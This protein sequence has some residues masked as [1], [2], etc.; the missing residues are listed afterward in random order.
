MKR[1]IIHYI[2]P[3]LLAV[4]LTV[5][6]G[7]QGRQ[8]RANECNA[9]SLMNDAYEEHN[10]ERLVTLA[11]SLQ[12][13]KQLSE[14]KAYYWRGYSYSRQRKMRLAESQWKKA[15]G[16]HVITD[17]DLEYYAKSVN[18]LTAL[19]LLKGD[20]EAVMREAV[21]AIQ[22]LIDAG[23][24]NTSDYAFIQ[25]TVG[26]CQLRLGSQK[27]A[28]ASFERAY[29]IF[30]YVIDNNP[31]IS[32]Y[33]SAIAG[34]ITITDNHLSMKLFAEALAWSNRFAELID[35]YQQ[36]AKPDMDY[37][38]KQLARINLYRA[39]ALEGLGNHADAAKA[40]KEAMAT[41]Y[42]KTIDGRFETCNYLMSASRW[43]EAAHNFEVLD[44]LSSR[45]GRMFNLDYI[46]HFLLPK[47]KANIGAHNLDTA[48]AVGTLICNNLD[49]AI[50][51]VQLDEAS[52]LA[53]IYNTQQKETE[54]A[55]QKANLAR[56]QFVIVVIILVLV[57]IFFSLIMFFRHQSAKRLAAAYCKLEEANERIKE[58]SRMKT[59]F[60]QQISH[61]IRTPLNILSGFTQVITT[62]GMTLDEETKQD[63]NTKIMEN[64]NRI[65]GLVNKMLELSDVNS[66][67]VIERND[68]V[69]AIQVAAEAMNA[70]TDDTKYTIPIDLQLAEGVDSIMLQTNEQAATRSL[71]LVLGNA[72]R[73]TKEGV[74]RLK[75]EHDATMVRFVVEDTGIG[76]PV[77]EAEHIFEEFV[78]L[79]EYEEGTGIGLTVSRSICRRLGGDVVLDT[80]YT[81]GAR[82]VL[83]L[84]LT[85]EAK[86]E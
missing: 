36:Q 86:A 77:S 73:F 61:E 53:A 23:K 56:Q 15:I 9:D 32:N 8:E 16:L 25:A 67:A 13:L 60:I 69:L 18:R 26:C 52:E 12:E 22:L 7:E 68:Q 74:V 29:Q 85:I 48:I 54:L 46:Q 78:Q 57:I 31:S 27:E 81:G 50:L 49:S 5:S 70:F 64:T 51:R 62:P 38:D 47:Y 59:S 72:E 40:Y 55:E 75:V 76:V 19:Q 71:V 21:P 79:N 3:V 41:H 20:Y 30:L 66:K 44:Q 33:T 1:S 39:C 65:T 84:P 80:S 6:C 14:M 28:A 2:L 34:I 83:T 58:S 11:D 63:I 45:Y 24:N 37:L 82:F 43:K 4:C 17:E 35:Q 42:A 10:Y